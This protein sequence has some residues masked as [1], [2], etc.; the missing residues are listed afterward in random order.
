MR[1]RSCHHTQ[2]CEPQLFNVKRLVGDQTGTLCAS[3]A[4]RGHRP[5]QGAVPVA[6]LWACRDCSVK[7]C[8]S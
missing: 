7:L 4:L 2:K 3:G 5:R 8:L 1:S 6:E